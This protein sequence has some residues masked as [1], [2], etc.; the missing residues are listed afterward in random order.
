MTVN[1]G[2]RIWKCFDRFTESIKSE[3]N[4]NKSLKESEKGRALNIIKRPE[5][6]EGG[7]FLLFKK[8]YLYIKDGLFEEIF[9]NNYKNII[10]DIEN[11]DFILKDGDNVID[12]KYYKERTEFTETEREEYAPYESAG[13]DVNAIMFRHYNHK[14]P[15][16]K[17][18]KKL[19]YYKQ[20]I[21][22]RGGVKETNS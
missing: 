9:I 13:K 15:L 16:F 19:E 5:E 11:N 2:S 6:G 18:K 14:K 10:N 1:Y 21:D 20:L 17:Y 22:D 4:N 8:F 3:I 12:L 7:F